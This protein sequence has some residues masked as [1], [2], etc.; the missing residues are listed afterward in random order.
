MSQ[1]LEMRE[2]V[3]F[4]VEAGLKLN[5]AMNGSLQERKG[6]IDAAEI[7]FHDAYALC[8]YIL[9]IHKIQIHIALA[10]SCSL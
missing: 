6:L 5:T 2:A 1:W 7:P 3:H 10:Q 8:R 9:P 4:T